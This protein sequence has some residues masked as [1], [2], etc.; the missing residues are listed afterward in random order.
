[1]LGEPLRAHPTEVRGVHGARYSQSGGEHERG[2]RDGEDD[3]QPHP[4]IV[5]LLR[6]CVCAI[7][8]IFAVCCSEH[9]LGWSAVYD[10][11]HEDVSCPVEPFPKVTASFA[12]V[13]PTPERY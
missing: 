1:V 4:I 9:P 8:D 3:D 12:L 10:L 7:V 2:H 5:S 6:V 13:G 11:I